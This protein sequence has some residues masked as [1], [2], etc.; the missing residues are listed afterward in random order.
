MRFFSYRNKRR[1]RLIL[2]GLALLVVVYL[3]FVLCRFIYLQ[4]FLV[5]SPDGV[6]LNYEQDLQSDRKQEEETAPGAS[7]FSAAAGH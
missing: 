4:R 1:I 3:G 2:L 6:T 7:A 5:Y